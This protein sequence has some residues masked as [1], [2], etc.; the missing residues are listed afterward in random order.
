[1]SSLY[2][3]FD[4]D[5]AKEFGVEQAI[6]IG[7]FQA[8]IRNNAANGRNFEEGRTWSFNTRKALSDE[9][10]FWSPSQIRR[11]LNS[12]IE[13]S[14]MRQ[15]EFNKK[16]YDRTLWYAFE[17]EYRFLGADF[18][19]LTE[20]SNGSDE[21][22]KSICRNRQLEVTIPSTVPTI[23][24]TINPI[25]AA[26]PA[27]KAHVHPSV[28]KVIA[29][30]NHPH[31]D[32]SKSPNLL[33]GGATLTHWIEE[34]IDLDETIIPAITAQ[35]SRHRGGPVQQWNYFRGAVFDAHRIRMEAAKPIDFGESN[36]PAFSSPAPARPAPQRRGPVPIS[37]V[38]LQAEHRAREAERRRRG[39][40][41]D[42][43]ADESG[44]A[45]EGVSGGAALLTAS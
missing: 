11:L 33:F 1:M 37:D 22:D 40:V 38:F 42:W 23:N 21:I 3:T 7:R 9:F 29:E 31:L 12:L 26:A 2:F 15:G 30:V 27:R 17:D 6:L 24:P 10:P 25:A 28:E 39:S 4:A 44:G 16:G 18:V 43:S 20:S 35:M 14:V 8:W 32:L 45:H 5:L 19:Q 13:R 34:G 41:S 36:E